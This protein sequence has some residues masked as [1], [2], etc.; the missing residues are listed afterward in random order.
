ML[1]DVRRKLGGIGWR[2][3]VNR[4][5]QKLMHVRPS[6][7]SMLQRLLGAAVKNLQIECE[8]MPEV[9]GASH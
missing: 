4:C 1:G 3:V 9:I 2:W 7:G 6:V 5:D 8:G